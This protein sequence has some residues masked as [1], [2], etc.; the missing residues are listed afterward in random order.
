M[1]C[2][3]GHALND[4][5]RK[6]GSVNTGAPVKVKIEIVVEMIAHKASVS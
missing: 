3:A 6:F 5:F 1:E 4:L 2:D